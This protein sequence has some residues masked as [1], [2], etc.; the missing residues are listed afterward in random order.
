V[1]NA[2]DKLITYFDADDV[3]HTYDQPKALT[4]TD[5]DDVYSNSVSGASISALGGNDSIENTADNVM[6]IY[7]GGNDSISGFNDSSTLKITEGIYS[8]E[9]NGESGEDVRVNVGDGSILLVGAASLA[10]VNIDGISVNDT[11]QTITNENSSPVTV[12]PV[13][14]VIDASA[15]TKKIKITAND[16]N[17]S[18]VGGK[19]KDTIY[20]GAGSDSI[21]GERAMIISS[22][23]RATTN[24]SAAPAKIRS[25]AAT[26][27]ILCGAAQAP[28]CSFTGTVTTTTQSSI[29]RKKI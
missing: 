25:W 20:G 15:R 26:A 11:L 2:A 5:G 9:E 16:L 28:T 27:T 12:S 24:C 19:S 29:T 17:N 6:F 23:G 13:A 7:G 10:S 3:K 8:T 4:L 14:E 22:A 21:Y 18:I 1:K